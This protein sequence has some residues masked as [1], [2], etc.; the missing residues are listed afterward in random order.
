[1]GLGERRTVD[2]QTE[3]ETEDLGRIRDIS[4]MCG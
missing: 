3:V 2:R 1:M 4:C